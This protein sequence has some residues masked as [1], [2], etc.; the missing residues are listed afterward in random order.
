MEKQYIYSTDDEFLQLINRQRI[1]DQYVKITLLDWNENPISEIQGLITGGSESLN[2]NSAV[3]RT[4]NLSMIV[5]DNIYSITDVNNLISINKKIFLEVGIENKTNQYLDEKII[6]FPQGIFVVN[7]ANSSHSSNGT[8][9][10]LQLKDKMC[11]LNGECGGT[12]PAST[13]F[14]EWETIDDKGNILISK[15]VVSQIIRE[16]VNHFGGEQLSK[17]IISD[18]DDRI[19]SVM[20]WIGNTPIYMVSNNGNYNLTTNYNEIKDMEATQKTFEAGNQFSFNSN[21]GFKIDKLVVDGKSTQETS[22]RGINYCPDINKWGLNNGAYIENGY[23]VLPKATANA[24]SPF[25]PIDKQQ[26]SWF[27]Y[28]KVY[29]E[30]ENNKL[31]CNT[32]YYDGNKKRLS[33]NGN[34]V[35]IGNVS[36]DNNYYWEFGGNSTSKYGQALHNAK[37]I[38]IVFAYNSSYSNGAYKIKAPMITSEKQQNFIPYVP[39]MPS[40]N[41]PSK[42]ECVKSKNLLKGLSTS[43]TNTTYWNNLNKNYFTPLSN[44]WGRWEVDN[45]SGT[46]TIFANA[47]V[48]LSA[49]DL[50]PGTTYTFVVEI[51]NSTI[52]ENP[53][54]Y[55]QIITNNATGAFKTGRLIGYQDINENKTII[56]NSVTKDSFNGVTRG[57]DTYLRLGAGTKG[58][59]EARISLFE[60][61]NNISNTYVPYD[62]IQVKNIGKNL[63][64]ENNLNFVSTANGKVEINNHVITMTALKTVSSNDLFVIGKIDDSLLVNGESYT[65][66]SV[67][68]SG[69]AQSFRL[70]L[71]NKDGSYVASMPASATITYDDTYS[72]YVINN[73]FS[74][75]GSVIVSEGTV[76]IVKN[77]KVERGTQITTYEP[78]QEKILNIDLKGNELCSL[79]NGVKDELVIENGRT[80]IIKKIGKIIFDGSENWQLYE[81]VGS[82]PRRFGLRNINV[83]ENLSMI[84]NYFVCKSKSEGHQIDLSL[85]TQLYYY[86]ITDINSYW[87]NATELKTWLSTHNTIVYYELAIPTE[88]D[89]GEINTLS[90]FE[91]ANNLLI[92][93]NLNTTISGSYKCLQGDYGHRMFSYGD[94]IGFIYTDFT[95]PTEL[96]GNAGDNVTT[97]LDKIKS[98]LGNNYEYFYDVPGNFRF[99]EIKNYLNTKQATIEIKKLSNSDY[100]VDMAKGKRAYNL[101]STLG[102]SYSNNPQ[103]MNIKNDYVVWGARKTGDGISVPIRYHLAIDK[104]P[105]IGNI[106]NCFFYLDPDDGLEKATIPIEYQTKNNF[107]KVG[108]NKTY[109]LDKSTNVIYMWDGKTESYLTISGLETTGYP[110]IN[111]FPSQGD[112]KKVYVDQSTLNR[113]SWAINQ[114]SDHYLDI[115]TQKKSSYINYINTIAPMEDK[116]SQNEEDIKKDNFALEEMGTIEQINAAIADVNADITMQQATVNMIK[117]E[118]KTLEEEKEK[119]TSEE[120]KQMIQTEINNYTMEL[121]LEQMALENLQNQLA[122][123]QN[124]LTQRPI[125]EQEIL[126]KQKENKNLKDKIQAEL[127]KYNNK[128]EELSNKEYEYVLTESKELTKIKTT[129]WRTELYLQGV[130]AE[131]LG[132]NSNY[133]YPELAAEWPKIYNLKAESYTENGE[134]I[135]TG[136][137]YQEVKD[138]PEELTYFLDFIDS[139]AEISKFSVSNIG[140]RSLV[141]SS[142]SFNCIFEPD[143]PDFVLIESGQT[144]TAKKRQECEDKGQPYIQVSSNIYNMLA[145]GGSS[146]S[147]FVEIKNLLYNH[148]KYNESIQVQC[149]P[150]YQIEPN[151]RIGVQ[152]AQSNIFGDY[153]INTISL[154]L[155]PNG[156]MSIS[157]MRALEKL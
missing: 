58:T 99:Q 148:T 19:K 2:G 71:R 68:V 151:I 10:S 119:A 85:W 145:L 155:A 94:D 130:M 15:P 154:P 105:K 83:S 59:V 100:L 76:A 153:M 122:I 57:V 150:I 113:Y 1:Q 23:I 50:K 75:S 132:V 112:S 101:D 91:G 116:I 90:T 157:A 97:I 65:I 86:A 128:V 137:F 96:I 22:T 13:Q 63:F 64:N 109:Y 111:D 34:A 45:T 37:Y 32:E 121:E 106:Y 36:T 129:D 73:P 82:T 102:T 6:W 114:Q 18:I 9:I 95:F 118:I 12:I 108:V 40:P 77:I 38:K 60:Y 33:G 107:P 146:N 138:H 84:S 125:L 70:Q 131:P 74:T 92:D 79:L 142:D 88:I 17:I 30:V 29:T 117:Q 47:M 126:D 141:E 69:M 20:K 55:L 14:D 31:L 21:E 61:G 89:L 67:N 3:R 134:T 8:V 144:D 4:C 7:S 35:L 93:T 143:V 11:T 25:I 139:N 49:I 103:Y 16:A 124:Y 48:N 133:Y 66:S 27:A 152:D 127:E 26:Y 62:T 115:Q 136:D 51:R 5:K 80:K 24:V 52:S 87:A 46:S 53:N 72:L 43:N 135:Y 104:K 28:A 39:N 44:G 156:T 98:T 147:C 123:L 81:K 149:L 54:A 42:V 56:F 110:T 140:R 78:Y 120:E 41:Y